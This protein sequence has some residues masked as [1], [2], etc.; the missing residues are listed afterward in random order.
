MDHKLQIAR[1]QLGTALHL[2]IRDKD[3]ISVHALACGGYEIV[4]GLAKQAGVKPIVTHLLALNPEL[5]VKEMVKLRNQY[6]NCFKHYYKPDQS[7]V[8]DDEELFATFS[9]TANDAALYLGWQDYANVAG[10]MPIE[11]QVFHIWWC[12]IYIE[13]LVPGTDLESVMR[14]FPDIGKNER[15]EQKRRLRRAVEKYRKDKAVMADPRT[16]KFPL[17]VGA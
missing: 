2:F 9:D 4:E 17:L 12:A 16:E 11:A 5:N 8:R 15:Q 13:K 6:W 14:V 3:P 10:K 1:A 7:T